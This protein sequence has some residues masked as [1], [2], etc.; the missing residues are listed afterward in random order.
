[1]SY[2]LLLNS[3]LLQKWTVQGSRGLLFETAV[4]DNARFPPWYMFFRLPFFPPSF[5]EVQEVWF[6]RH[7]YILPI[8]GEMFLL[9]EVQLLGQSFMINFAFSTVEQKEIY[10]QR[11]T[12]ETPWNSPSGATAFPRPTEQTPLQL[13]CFRQPKFSFH[14]SQVGTD[15]QTDRRAATPHAFDSVAAWQMPS[16][17][18]WR[19][20]FSAP[21]CPCP[22]SILNKSEWAER[23]GRQNLTLHVSLL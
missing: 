14:G 5:D 12:F 16:S 2:T 10:L 9:G 15:R 7:K 6:I 19:A 21:V 1:M 11:I 18:P 20:L 13:L 22:G 4:G 17:A 3:N 8:L 23:D